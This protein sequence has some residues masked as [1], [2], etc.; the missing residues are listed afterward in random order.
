MTTAALPATDPLQALVPVE[1]QAAA[2]NLVGDVV[3]RALLVTVTDAPSLSRA[4]D[5]LLGIRDL[6]TAVIEKLKPWT[7]A[8]HNAHKAL[9]TFRDGFTSR[10]TL[11]DRH[12]VGQVNAYKR[13]E[14]DRLRAEQEERDRLAAAARAKVEEKVLEVAVEA[15]KAGDTAGAQALVEQVTAPRLPVLGP[16][17]AAITTPGLS[18]V[19]RYRAQLI[20]KNGDTRES[21]LAL[22]R[23][24]AS[25]EAPV[26]FLVLDQTT[27]NALARKRKKVGAWYPG[28]EVASEDGLQR[29]PGRGARGPEEGM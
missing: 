16:T 8:A 17:A 2:N 22:I 27:A 20:E 15:E 23:A 14:E 25:G 6:Q 9:T 1:A 21:L 24:V 28:L 29:S 4:T 10:L 26:E 5:L 3:D 18:T 11:A 19:T 7:T 12:L 13:R